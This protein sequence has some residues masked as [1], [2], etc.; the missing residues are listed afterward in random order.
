MASDYL[1]KE[2]FMR[3]KTFI[4]SLIVIIASIAG[5]SLSAL[6]ILEYFGLAPAAA[7]IV[8]V[9]DRAGKT[10]FDL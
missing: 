6:L 2:M 7:D 5:L 3:N 1:M 4:L 9:R 10:G 8:C